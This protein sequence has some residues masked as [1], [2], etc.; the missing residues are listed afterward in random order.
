MSE[1]AA[2]TAKAELKKAI[3]AGKT[4]CAT[5]A[6]IIGSPKKERMNAQLKKHCNDE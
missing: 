5:L 6:T 4:E 3:K 1:N 2:I